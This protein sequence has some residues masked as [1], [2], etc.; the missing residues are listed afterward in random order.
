MFV[1]LGVKITRIHRVLEFDQSPWLK[2]YI[3]FNT[4]KR[5]EATCQFAKDFFKLMNC[6]V[7]G[8]AQ[9][10]Q[11]NRVNVELITDGKILK[12]RVA[13]PKF[14]CGIEINEELTIIQSKI[15]TLM[16]NRPI[17][18]GFCVLDLGYLCTI[19]ITII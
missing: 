18:D 2:P 9:E 13:N 7:Y 14:N 17:Y 12:K 5:S 19:S 4:K 3:D 6:S 8:K 10:N 1:K 16:L 15:A 11:R